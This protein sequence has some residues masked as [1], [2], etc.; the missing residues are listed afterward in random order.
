MLAWH[1]VG[2]TL[3]DGRPV[4]AD[5]VT[6]HHDGQPVPCK[7]GLHASERLI[8]ALI[9]APGSWACRV[10][11]GGAIIPHGNP[12]DK[13]VA[14]ERTIL[15][16]A[17]AT[18]VLR[19]FARQQAL[20]VAYLWAIPQAVR[21]YLETGQDDLLDAAPL[22]TAWVATGAAAGG[23]AR[24][25]VCAAVWAVIGAVASRQAA[26]R[27]AREAARAAAGET[28]GEAAL[29]AANTTLTEMIE[30]ERHR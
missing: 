7:S 24:P 29:E 8:D 9:Y 13:H 11:L 27:A 21:E 19:R 5:G 15:W 1:F 17:D 14:T 3:R 22:P 2:D 4:P 26:W 28:A 6:L 10:E 12:V 23:A 30:A 25:A 16:R 20:S 18:D